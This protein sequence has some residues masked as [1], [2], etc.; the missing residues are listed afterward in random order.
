MKHLHV[1]TYNLKHSHT[2][3]TFIKL[4][5]SWIQGMNMSKHSAIKYVNIGY[6]VNTNLIKQD[7]SLKNDYNKHLASVHLNMQTKSNHLWSLVCPTH[8]Q[9]KIHEVYTSRNKI[10]LGHKRDVLK[11]YWQY[12]KSTKKCYKALRYSQTYW[13]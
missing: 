2:S 4:M 8:D 3:K 6:H 10:L 9:C 1:Y 7:Q 11:T 12:L 5:T 13:I